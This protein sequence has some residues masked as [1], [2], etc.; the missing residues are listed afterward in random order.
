[1]FTNKLIYVLLNT[2]LKSRIK[3]TKAVNNKQKEK[4]GILKWQ[5]TVMRVERE[6]ERE[7]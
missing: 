2:T 4:G 3:N 6:R 7:L 5:Q 1:M